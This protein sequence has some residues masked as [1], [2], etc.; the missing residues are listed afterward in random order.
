M[1]KPLALIGFLLLDLVMLVGML[2]LGLVC[3]A[4]LSTDPVPFGPSL[5]STGEVFRAFAGSVGFMMLSGYFV[6]AGALTLIF[7]NRLFSRARAIWLSLLFVAHAVV[8]LFYLMGPAVPSTSAVLIAIGVV[9]VG[10]V[11]IFENVLCRR[12]FPHRVRQS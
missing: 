1:L 2:A 11:T 4:A 3:F 6:S 8:F 10:V 7:R 12:W 9:C 5:L